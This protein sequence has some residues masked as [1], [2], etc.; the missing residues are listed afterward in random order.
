MRPIRPAVPPPTPRRADARAARA[1]RPLPL[2]QAAEAPVARPLPT[3]AWLSGGEAARHQAGSPGC[4]GRRCAAPL[5][6]V[7]R[8]GGLPG[9]LLPVHSPRMPA[10]ACGHFGPT[11]RL[12]CI[13]NP[14]ARPPATLR[15][16]A[17]AGHHHHVQAPGAEAPATLQP[18]QA[19]GDEGPAE[20][21]QPAQQ[22]KRGGKAAKQS[23][24]Q[25]QQQQQQQQQK[26]AASEHDLVP[27]ADGAH[28][29]SSLSARR[30]GSGSA[31]EA[32]DEAARH[33]PEAPAAALRR[34]ISDSEAQAQAE[35]QVWLGRCVPVLDAPPATLLSTHDPC[36]S[37]CAP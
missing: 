24:R 13:P 3:C 7:T 1:A 21:A 17:A 22:P 12:A 37:S 35:Q 32:N 11:R 28:R 26:Q 36:A 8:A 19:A 4:R 34:L 14:R 31:P 9:L 5:R 16:H 18:Q 25:Q 23:Q 6:A 15:A 33:S 27:G 10:S 30:M 29:R 2:P 20:G